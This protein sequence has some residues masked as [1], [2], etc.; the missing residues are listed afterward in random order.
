MMEFLRKLNGID[1]LLIALAVRTVYSAIN[2]GFVAE[3]IKNLGT[4]VAVFAAFHYYVKLAVLIGHFSKFPA[5]ATQTLSFAAIWLVV[6]FVFRYLRDGLGM[7]FTV[8]TISVVDRWGAAIISVAR[9]FLTASLFLFLFL[10]TGQP[11]MQHITRASFSQKY[12]LPVAPEAY[13]K[14]T[15]GL[16]TK[17]YPDEKVNQAVFDQLVV[18]G[19]R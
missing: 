2:S 17:F 8:Q 10:L 5:P 7:V 12:V 3:L 19:K 13:R 14:I 6:L 11:Y 1:L 9:F 15:Q 4:L 18:T 16:V